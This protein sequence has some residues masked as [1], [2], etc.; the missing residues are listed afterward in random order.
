L[1][2]NGS[3]TVVPDLNGKALQVGKTYNITA[4]PA[5]GYIPSNWVAVASGA[6]NQVSTAVKYTFAPTTNAA[7][8][9]A[10]FVTNRFFDVAGTYNGL[11][12]ETG[13]VT[14][15]SAGFASVKVKAKEGKPGI[16]SATLSL[17]GEKVSASGT[18]GLDGKAVNTKPVVFK[19]SS[20]TLTVNI[21]L[22]FDGSDK[23]SGSVS[24][25]EVAGWVA[26]L[27]A[28]RML[29]NTSYAG[30]YTLVIPGTTNGPAGDGFG[31]LVVDSIGTMKVAGTLGDGSAFSQKV[32][33]SKNGDWPFFATANA[34]TVNGINVKAGT[35]MG[36]LSLA[37][38][39]GTPEGTLYWVKNPVSTD[40][41]Y[42]A[43]FATESDILSSVYSNTVPVFAWTNGTL[44]LQ[45]GNLTGVLT[46][47]AALSALN[48]FSFSTNYG[49]KLT[50]TYKTGLIKGT[51]KNPENA[52]AV[53]TVAGAVLQNDQ[54]GRGFIKGTNLTGAFLLQ[55]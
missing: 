34:T 12:S 51:F 15:A 43:G 25:N 39:N 40:I 4:K 31:S 45:G 26:A 38:T 21:T 2:A 50:L 36:W 53:T 5:L 42:P 11:F 19:S 6:T 1:L 52:N 9:I 7:T 3:G 8:L 13:G 33:V 49:M 29:T 47:S 28:D 18:F 46:N 23:V 10:N 48:K 20:N 16:F 55:P 30:L 24:N 41:Y 17:A 22:P 54:I 32:P 35:I 14:V 27:D 44:T 37:N